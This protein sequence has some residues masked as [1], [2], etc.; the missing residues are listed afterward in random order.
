MLLVGKVARKK[1]AAPRPVLPTT[2]RS[3]FALRMSSPGY[4]GRTMAIKADSDEDA[5]R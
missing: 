3:D 5:H 1:T 2:Y 4:A